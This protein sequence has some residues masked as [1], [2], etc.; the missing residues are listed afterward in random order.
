MLLC[1]ADPSSDAQHWCS[2]KF[3][4]R[5]E[6]L[7]GQSLK[8]QFLWVNTKEINTN[9]FPRGIREKVNDLVLALWF[10]ER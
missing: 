8:L 1:R 4:L 5:T 10:L 6:W 7:E 2:V 9:I 3:W